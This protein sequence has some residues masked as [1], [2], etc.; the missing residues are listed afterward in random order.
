MVITHYNLRF[1]G[2][3]SARQIALRDDDVYMTVM[4]TR[5]ISIV[6]VPPRACIL[7]WQHLCPARGTVR[8][9]LGSGT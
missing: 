3:Y 7:R 2:Y 4:P 5:F 9:L 8:G 1:A 6:S